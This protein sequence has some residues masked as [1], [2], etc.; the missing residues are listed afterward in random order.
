MQYFQGLNNGQF[1][2]GNVSTATSFPDGLARCVRV[3]IGRGDRKESVR[4]R[5][6]IAQL[7]FEMTLP[8]AASDRQ[9]CFDA[10]RE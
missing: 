4:R 3:E 9:W 7:A 8:D 5:A 10:S 6:G 2:T 1:H